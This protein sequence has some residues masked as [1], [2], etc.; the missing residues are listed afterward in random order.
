MRQCH[1]WPPV[2]TPARH[3]PH[4][5]TSDPPVRTIGSLLPQK[6]SIKDE[7]FAGAE[8]HANLIEA[9]IEDGGYAHGNLLLGVFNSQN[10]SLKNIRVDMLRSESAL[11]GAKMSEIDARVTSLQAENN[12]LGKY[13]T[14]EGIEKASAEK[15]PK[16]MEEAQAYFLK[17]G[18][19]HVDYSR[20]QKAIH[21]L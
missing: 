9:A 1:A 2:C 13:T 16:F 3:L 5:P 14:A 18:M 20:L 10:K 7:I 15:D 8:K 12:T 19:N 17:T 21:F 4:A 6:D 11:A